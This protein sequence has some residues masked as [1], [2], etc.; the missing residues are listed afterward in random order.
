MTQNSQPRLLLQELWSRRKARTSLA[1]FTEFLDL[2]YK[3][4]RHHRVIIDKLEAVERGEIKRLMLFLPPGSAKST[5]ASVLFAAW[6]LGRNPDKQVIAASHTAELAETFGRRVRNLVGSTDYR[7]VFPDSHLSPDSQAAGRWDMDEGG[8]YFAVGVGGSVTGRRADVAILDDVVRSRED[9]DSETVRG[10]TWE[11]YKADLRTRL[12]PQGSIVLI[13]TRW[14]S[15]DLAGRL[16]KDQMD[17]G[18][19]W[20]VVSLQMEAGEGD[21]LGRKPGELLWPEWFTPDM[22]KQAKRDSRNWAALYQQSPTL[23]GGNILKAHWWKRWP[24]DKKLPVCDHVFLS[25]DTAYSEAGYK[26]NA[27]SAYLAFGVFWHEA[28]DRHC[29]ILLK[30]WHGQVDY[31]ELRRKAKDADKDLEPDAHL[32]EKKASGISLVQDMRRIPGVRVRTY[33]PDRDKV[34]RAYSVQA[35]LESGQVYAPDRRWA[36]NVI[37]HVSQFPN[38]APPSADLTDCL[39]QALIYLRNG[40][41]VEH[42]DDKLLPAPD[43]AANT[44]AWDEDDEESTTRR[45]YG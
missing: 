35:M 4:A 30:A 38:G 17:G 21:P 37:E 9:A 3:P 19:Q 5:Y 8:G 12:K 18:D 14:H 42:P 13:M 26:G 23:D 22:V 25:W 20:D 43:V 2:G 31:P 41:W 32:I 29:L 33:Q 45:L 27:H 34:T 24:E 1:S 39:T 28:E 44:D 11:W 7:A 15:D 16:L 6:Y 40:Y 36:D 10:K